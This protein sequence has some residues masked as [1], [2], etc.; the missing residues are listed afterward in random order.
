M[1]FVYLRAVPSPDQHTGSAGNVPLTSESTLARF[2]Y[3]F[4]EDRIMGED[5]LTGSVGKHEGINF[6]VF[7]YDFLNDLS[8]IRPFRTHLTGMVCELEPLRED[9]IFK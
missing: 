2:S 1:L 6:Q 8:R 4:H 3:Y 5:A 7:G 9:Y